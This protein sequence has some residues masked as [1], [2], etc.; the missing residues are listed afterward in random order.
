MLFGHEHV[1]RY[2]ETNGEVGHDWQGTTVL[3]LTTTGRRS[4]LQRSTPLI[5]RRDGDDY[6]VV[7][8]NGGAE[9]HP[10]WYK[11][12]SAGSEVELQ[13]KADRV[14]ARARDASAEEKA[15]LWPYMAEVWPD[16]D[17]YQAK[18]DRPIPV[19]VLEPRA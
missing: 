12:L 1:K 9:D 7:A 6:V 17:S 13:V 15:R 11:N 14:P 5:Y 3:I 10:S 2:M 18:T 8:S 19:V 16:Y 4:G